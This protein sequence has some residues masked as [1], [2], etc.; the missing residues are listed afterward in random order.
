MFPLSVDY[1]MPKKGETT[2]VPHGGIVT[3]LLA[4]LTFHFHAS[5]F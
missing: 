2:L 3:I 4:S 1:L 5:N